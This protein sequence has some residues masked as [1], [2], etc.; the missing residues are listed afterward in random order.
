MA[1]TWHSE[2]I[3]KTKVLSKNGSDVKS[4]ISCPLCVLCS[5]GH[6]SGTGRVGDGILASS[7]IWSSLGPVVR[8]SPTEEKKH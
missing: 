8:K 3:S 2:I 6:P 1:A 7:S 5:A 4:S